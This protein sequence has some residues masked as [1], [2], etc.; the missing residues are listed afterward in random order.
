M[1]PPRIRSDAE[2]RAMFARM[3][4]RHYPAA[5]SKGPPANWPT[6]EDD[7]RRNGRQPWWPE[8]EKMRRADPNGPW[9]E[10]GAASGVTPLDEIAGG[11]YEQGR[12]RVEGLYGDTAARMMDLLGTALA[13]IGVKAGVT[14]ALATG[15]P[16]EK[17]AVGNLLASLGT[18]LSGEAIAEY[19]RQHPTMNPVAERAL[20][21]VE[22]ILKT[23][24]ALTGLRSAKSAAAGAAW[25][26]AATATATAQARLG[27]AG[28]A[29]MTALRALGSKL[30]SAVTKP[31]GWLAKAYQAIAN[32]TGNELP[33]AVGGIRTAAQQ[34]AAGATKEG[35]KSLVPPAVVTAGVAA[36]EA[37]EQS[38]IADYSRRIR[39]AWDKGEA[40]V[41]DP[42]PDPVTGPAS[43][44]AA[45]AVGTLGNPV[46]KQ[47]RNYFGGRYTGDLADL[48]AYQVAYEHIEAAQARGDLSPTEA[49][50]AKAK[51]ADTK[52][53]WNM[54]G[55]SLYSFTPAAAGLIKY[56]AGKLADWLKTDFDY[57]RIASDPALPGVQERDADTI[58]LEDG[59]SVRYLGIDSTEIAHAAK[60]G[61]KDEYAAREATARA[62]EI[63]PDGTV[64]RLRAGGPDGVDVDKYGRELR[65]VEKIPDL[66]AAIPGLRRIWPGTDVGGTLL[67]EGL[68][69]PRYGELG[70]QNARKKDYD[71]ATAAAQAAALGV[72]SPE[73]MESVDYHY[74]IPDAKPGESLG[75]I[76]NLAGTGLLTT[77]QSGAFRALGPAGNLAAQAW[78]AA[79]SA[80]GTSQH[81]K[82]GNA[83]RGKKYAIAKSL[84]P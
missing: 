59:R 10:G 36:I 33:A 68:A 1:S 73:G 22:A 46:E 23:V 56:Q 61:S 75:T 57:A 60:P 38:R 50:D 55:R 3:G 12:E 64:V 41:L 69:Q 24:S 67:E 14:R 70:A 81:V 49:E 28:N 58:L 26:Y 16:R 79:M 32:F 9:D 29:V 52:K 78:N 30:P 77:G 8:Y 63:A 80:I 66:V 27:Q 47:T 21:K 35:F 51:L 11:I 62:K 13:L 7:K 40:F 53:P 76:G 39:D 71:A 72:W 19:R 4:G 25:R 17:T 6:Y 31:A 83:N 44:A 2:R 18:G 43:A 65:Y 45:F 48:A 74:K 37:F 20:A 42:D 84:A 34:F 82:A 15:A 5:S 54:A